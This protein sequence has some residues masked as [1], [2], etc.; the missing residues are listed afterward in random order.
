MVNRRWN[1]K[2][3]L[4]TNFWWFRLNRFPKICFNQTRITWHTNDWKFKHR[5]YFQPLKKFFRWNRNNMQKPNL[6]NLISRQWINRRNRKDK[7]F[8]FKGIQ[9][10]IKNKWRFR[11]GRRDILI[12]RWGIK[13]GF[14]INIRY[15]FIYNNWWWGWMD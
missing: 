6:R 15:I 4:I 2:T 3:C 14:E 9:R 5:K 1:L 10:R 13:W 12:N 8:V 7:A 11:K